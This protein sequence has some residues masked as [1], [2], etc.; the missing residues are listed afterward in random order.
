MIDR[1]PI[2]AGTKSISNETKQ[3]KASLPDTRTAQTINATIVAKTI[4]TA[5]R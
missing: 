4:N 5:S 2:T 1:P 3:Y